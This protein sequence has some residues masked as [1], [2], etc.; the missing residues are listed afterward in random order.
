[1]EILL[2]VLAGSSLY[3]VSLSHDQL[4]I[5]QLQGLL[6]LTSLSFFYIITVNSK[7]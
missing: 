4:Y 1:M 7:V 6:I 2:V 3:F 5:A